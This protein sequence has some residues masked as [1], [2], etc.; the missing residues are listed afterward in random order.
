MRF[1]PFGTMELLII[2]VIVLLLFGAK[3]LPDVAKGLGQAIKEFRQGV[4]DNQEEQ[5]SGPAEPQQS[6]GRDQA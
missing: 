3:R 6:P 4:K 2:L 1:G 5:D